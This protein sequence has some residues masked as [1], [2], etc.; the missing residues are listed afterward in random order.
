M[1]LP[2]PS[3]EPWKWGL[4]IEQLNE[5]KTKIEDLFPNVAQDWSFYDLEEKWLRGHL[6]G[7]RPHG[8]ATLL[9]REQ[10]AYQNCDYMISHMWGENFFEFV[11]ALTARFPPTTVVWV[12]TF[13]IHQTSDKAMIA[14]QVAD[15]P[16]RSPFAR[17]IEFTRKTAVFV[18]CGGNRLNPSRLGQK[19]NLGN[20]WDRLWCVYELFHSHRVHAEVE[21]L[22]LQD[23]LDSAAMDDKFRVRKMGGR[24]RSPEELRQLM[25][26]TL[27]ATVDSAKAGCSEEADKQR[28]TEDIVRN[29]GF[30][31]VDRIANNL[32][33]E[34]L[35]SIRDNP[36]ISAGARLTLNNVLAAIPPIRPID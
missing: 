32:R 22:F 21:F 27:T 25:E 31:R 5:L 26:K 34:A 33:R 3:D 23:L 30:G 11:D 24:P 15:D 20:V 18:N 6:E 7:H 10:T 1:P 29:G 16:Q 8:Y 36:R 35:E 28:I 14:E 17:V 19:L 2:H 13:A 12:C 9:N 4:S